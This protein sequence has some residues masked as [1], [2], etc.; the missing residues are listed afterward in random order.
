MKITIIEDN[1]T[2]ANAIALRLE[3]HGHVITQI[4]NGADAAEFLALD[5]SD[6]VILDI[7]LPEKN[8][9]EILKE[10]RARKNLVPIIL[11]TARGLTS[12]RIEGLDIGA[13]DYLT[14]PFDMDELEARIRALLRRQTVQKTSQDM[15]GALSYDF[16]ARQVSIGSDI[17]D[18]PRRELA[19]FECL[20]MRQNQI[21]SKSR[22]ADHVFGLES[23]SNEDSVE[24]YVSR[25]RK[26]LMPHNVTIKSAR[27][28]GYML[29]EVQS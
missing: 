24:T 8:G 16:G 22:I 14:K 5:A 17:I 4:H 19:L 29:T 7:N 13:D 25:L 27:G 12:D 18:L 2:L 10:V 3:D 15:I 26:R 21:V 11:L 23:D 1:L 6:L 28:L 9:L 20:I